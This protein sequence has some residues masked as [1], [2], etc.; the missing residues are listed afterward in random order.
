M[1]FNKQK[2]TISAI[3]YNYNELKQDS[4]SNGKFVYLYIF[5]VNKLL[6]YLVEKRGI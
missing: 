2:L 4:T 1:N 3:P 5:L 6:T